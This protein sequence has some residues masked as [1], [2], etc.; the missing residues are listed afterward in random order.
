MGVLGA[1]GQA[2]ELVF[3]QVL[4]DRFQRHL[5]HHARAPGGRRGSLAAGGRHRSG[6]A[7]ASPVLSAGWRAAQFHLGFA[8]DAARAGALR[9][10]RVHQGIHGGQ[11]FKG[12][13]AVEDTRCVR[14]PGF[15]QQDA[16]PKTAVDGRAADEHREVQ[17]AALQFVD[18]QRHL[19]AGADQQRAE[20]NGIRV[21]FDGAWR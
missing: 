13:F 10:L 19:L 6:L 5:A 7:A 18:D 1:P 4:E 15:G 17:P 14:F 11:A 20:A 21:D 3:G 2:E 9:W 12:I 8:V 16:A